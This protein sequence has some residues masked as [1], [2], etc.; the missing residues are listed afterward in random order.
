MYPEQLPLWR[1]SCEQ[2]ND[3]ERAQVRREPAST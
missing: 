1:Q 3:W 2:A